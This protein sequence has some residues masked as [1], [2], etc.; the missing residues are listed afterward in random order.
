[1]A[2]PYQSL[3]KRVDPVKNLPHTVLCLA[4]VGVIKNMDW[5]HPELQTTFSRLFFHPFVV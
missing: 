1:M 5:H 2:R 3:R 4:M